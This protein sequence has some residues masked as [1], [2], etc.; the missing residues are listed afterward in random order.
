[1]VIWWPLL[2]VGG[3]T[4][5]G[6]Q[7]RSVFR[8]LLLPIAIGSTRI[9]VSGYHRRGAPA[10]H[11]FKLSFLCSQTILLPSIHVVSSPKSAQSPSGLSEL[12]AGISFLFYVLGICFMGS[13][14]GHTL[15]ES[16]APSTSPHR[17]EPYAMN[18]DNLFD[19]LFDG[20]Y[21]FHL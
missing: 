6:G 4:G 9:I 15:H 19:D 20:R 3:L 17:N 7:A 11:L 8:P 12:F 18:D 16:F 10:A 13:R 5:G 14:F 1:M 21:S 2:W